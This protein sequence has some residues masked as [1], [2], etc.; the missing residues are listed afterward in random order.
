MEIE[1]F[2]KNH[3]VESTHQQ[4]QIKGVKGN[5]NRAKKIL[6][7]LKSTFSTFSWPDD[8]DKRA[9]EHVVENLRKLKL[10]KDNFRMQTFHNKP[11][12]EFSRPLI[13]LYEAPVLKYL[14]KA[15]RKKV[16]RPTPK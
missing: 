11:L 8:T 7:H 13:P 15:E 10:K 4:D 6:V 9:I 16:G 3:D 2:P 1:T 5:R 12:F 14:V